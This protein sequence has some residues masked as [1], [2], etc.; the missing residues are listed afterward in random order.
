MGF[1]PSRGWAAATEQDTTTETAASE[2]EHRTHEAPTAEMP[3]M[4]Q[5]MMRGLR[6]RDRS[7]ARAETNAA[8]KTTRN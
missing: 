4:Q 6:V 3:Q 8:K 7:S 2:T 1:N 5:G